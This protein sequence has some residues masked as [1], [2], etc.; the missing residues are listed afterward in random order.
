[1][2]LPPLPERDKLDVAQKVT[3]GVAGAI[4][5]AGGVVAEIFDAVCPAPVEGKR[6]EWLRR[7]AHE[8]D[9]RPTRQELAENYGLRPE[10]ARPPGQSERIDPDRRDAVIGLF[11]AASLALLEWPQVT[12]GHWIERPEVE[13]INQ[14]LSNR[15]TKLVSL[16]GEPGSGK[17]A[18]LARAT[19]DLRDRGAIY[20]AIKA[21]LIPATV[22]SLD[23]LSR[24][25]GLSESVSTLLLKLAS[26]TPIIVLIDQLDA[27]GELMDTKTERFAV[28]QSLIDQLWVSDN[29]KIVVSSRSF[30]AEY[31]VRLRSIFGRR[32]CE[33]VLLQ[34]PEW[35]A[36]EPLMEAKGFKTQEWP[37]CVKEVLRAPQHLKLFLAHWS[38]DSS[39]PAFAT[40]TAL[41]ETVIVERVGRPFSQ[42]INALYAIAELIG[43]T[44]ELWIPTARVDAEFPSEIVQ[45]QEAG[46][47]V[48]RDS[49]H[50][51]GFQHQTLFSFIRARS[52][53]AQQRS[54]YE[55]TRRQQDSLS[56]RPTLWSAI[57]YLRDADPQKY[58][59][60]MRSILADPEIRPHVKLLIISFLGSRANPSAEEASW[61]LPLLRQDALIRPHILTAFR[62]NS[63]WLQVMKPGLLTEE[64]MGRDAAN[65]VAFFLRDALAIDREF[66]LS[67]IERSWAQRADCDEAIFSTLY[68]L[69]DWDDRSFAIISP[70]LRRNRLQD[71]FV[72]HLAE[73]M[74]RHRPDLAARLLK[75]QLEGALDRALNA[76]VTPTVS[77]Q[78][79]DLESYFAQ[80]KRRAPI[81]HF[82]DDQHAWHG[83]EAIAS[84][85]PREFVETLWPWIVK[86]SELVAEEPRTGALRYRPD[87]AWRFGERFCSHLSTALW[88]AMSLFAEQHTP[89]FLSF[90]KKARRADTMA[91]HRL[92]VRGFEKVAPSN[93]SEVIG[94]LVEDPRRLAVSESGYD[95]EDSRNLLELVG[96]AASDN[97]LD[98]LVTVIESWAFWI[99]PCD[100]SR[101]ASREEQNRADR[102]NL[103]AAL[104]RTRLPSRSATQMESFSSTRS[105]GR[106]EVFGGVVRSPVP[107][108][109]FAESTDKES[110]SILSEYPDSRERGPTLFEGGSLEIAREFAEFAKLNPARAT[111]IVAQL[112][113]G[114]QTL[115]A[116]CAL[117]AIAAVENY[118]AEQCL[119][120]ARELAAKGFTHA[121][122]FR[123]SYARAIEK[124]AQRLEGLSDQDCNL[125]ESLLSNAHQP[126]PQLSS[127]EL[128]RAS[129]DD[130]SILW[131]ARGG[132]LPDGNYPILQTLAIALL[133]R[134][135]PAADQFLEVLE[136]H[137]S[138]DE[139]LAV[140]Q[141]LLRFVPY[142]ASANRARSRAFIRELFQK[143][144]ALCETI[145]GVRFMATVHI[146]A[147]DDVVQQFLKSLESSAWPLALQALGEFACLRAALVPADTTAAV[148]VERA[149]AVD[150]ASLNKLALGVALS[151]AETWANPRFRGAN[152]HIL[153]R[154]I[155]KTDP[156][157]RATLRIFN[158]EDGERLPNDGQTTELLAVI[159][160]HLDLLRDHAAHSILVGL[161]ELLEDGFAPAAAARLG[162][163]VLE[164]SG[165]TVGDFRTTG[166]TLVKDLAALAFTFQ[167]Y[168]D[169]RTDGTWMF[170]RLLLD[171][172]YEIDSF[173]TQIDRRF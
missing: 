56:M 156:V 147:G 131:D 65:A 129:K 67:F 127:E 70:V 53:V 21:D 6:D 125:L 26:E 73:S 115:A 39:Q 170:E 93:G 106:P 42:A 47:L 172:A 149:L 69:K 72:V 54:L 97:E 110:L 134:K 83:I 159:A 16:L 155:G 145:D 157:R 148:I 2:A 38:K 118:S 81:K 91:V 34:I 85:G 9:D 61:I 95:I 161:R 1:M 55:F 173:A 133:V 20:L 169:T 137:L 109:R 89:E 144:P 117:E 51:L 99:E 105:R 171:S 66:T 98:L 5:L 80:E 11:G 86:L 121:E 140:W 116:G 35:T 166:P 139:D 71:F 75:E 31:E 168:P 49:G 96:P 78:Q 62:G 120:L 150:D 58:A 82:V 44:E 124:V 79:T 153:V 111:R 100:E 7:L 41:L 162:R 119:N 101:R 10:L 12:D 132:V 4:P 152:H 3:K 52:F 33:R 135:P 143:Y 158:R 128:R 50:R 112:R 165:N 167:R 60:E 25:W 136:R 63:T 74:V 126:A 146:W 103:L 19:C 88:Q 90:A 18:I 87:H 104:P 17:S 108:A 163:A 22:T 36:I 59:I 23:D 24:L 84:A 64:L 102:L 27:L 48:A 92:L 45:L 164:A 40:Y 76:I 13:R 141:S 57:N 68:D 154:M 123:H 160:E 14:L 77:E 29:I 130:E 46:L 32:G 138:R 15:D 113:P 30:D 151:A 43:E 8:V 37:A 142:L 28:L 107:A 94:Y 114:D 122:E